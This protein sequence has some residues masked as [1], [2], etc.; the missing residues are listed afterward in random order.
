MATRNDGS[1]G[2]QHAARY[3]RHCSRPSAIKRSTVNRKTFF[4]PAHVHLK[5]KHTSRYQT[6]TTLV[7]IT[8]RQMLSHAVLPSCKRLVCTSTHSLKCDPTF[9]AT[10]DRSSI[11]QPKHAGSQPSPLPCRAQRPPDHTCVQERGYYF[12]VSNAWPQRRKL[13][14]DPFCLWS[15]VL[16]CQPNFQCAPT[17]FPSSTACE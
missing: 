9:H 6:D 1:S 11:S 3:C 7:S 14:S 8:P 15:L 13:K 17:F 16:S 10:P 5:H 12:W 4:P 2:K